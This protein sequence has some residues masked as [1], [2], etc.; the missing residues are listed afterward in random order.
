MS[1]G[2]F[3]TLSRLGGEELRALVCVCVCVFFFFGGG[4]GVGFRASGFR[5]WRGFKL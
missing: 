5:P 3:S 4:G 1:E 2:R